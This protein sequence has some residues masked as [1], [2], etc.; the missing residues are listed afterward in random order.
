M[1]IISDYKVLVKRPVSES[2][3]ECVPPTEMVYLLKQYLPIHLGVGTVW[4]KSKVS[5]FEETKR[6][7]NA[8]DDFKKKI[9]AFNFLGSIIFIMN[10]SS[11][12]VRMYL[13]V[14]SN[15]QQM[16]V[17]SSFIIDYKYVFL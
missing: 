15:E 5:E 6:L 10:G 1:I 3:S 16:E 9:I 11:V 17:T 4:D 2:F 14:D 12:V 13:D 8:C 7:K